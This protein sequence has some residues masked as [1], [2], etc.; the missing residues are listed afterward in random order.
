ML[1]GLGFNQNPYDT[2][3][4]NKEVGGK[5]L[6]IVVYVDDLLCS[7]VDKRILESFI[8]ELRG[9]FKQ[10]KVSDFDMF[11]YLG[12]EID[13]TGPVLRVTMKKFSK[14]VLEE[15]GVVGESWVPAEED[16][17][18][19]DEGSPLLDASSKKQFHRTVA[20]LNYLV[21]R[22]RLE[23]LLCVNVLCSFVTCPTDQD[24]A[25][26]AKILC[27]L[28]KTRELGLSFQKGAPLRL[29]RSVLTPRM[30]SLVRV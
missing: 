19:R 2:C 25:K 27:F 9:K 8:A 21:K 17:L 20:R 29:R 16:L 15:L 6:T 11:E 7:C 23:F 18:Q 22:L 1:L 10:V 3:V 13:N 28:N 12:Y 24:A 4:F 14:M 30:A 26:L 5:K